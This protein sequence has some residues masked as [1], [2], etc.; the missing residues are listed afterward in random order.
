MSK[1]R[2]MLNFPV[3]LIHPYGATTT[4]SRFSEVRPVSVWLGGG[5]LQQ[6][7]SQNKAGDLGASAPQERARTGFRVSSS[8]H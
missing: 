3:P 8:P 6:G 2:E 1:N 4:G 5:S 7:V